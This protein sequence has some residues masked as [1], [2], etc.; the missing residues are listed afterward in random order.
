MYSGKRRDMLPYF[1]LVE[2][3]C[4]SYKNPSDYY[5]DLVTLDDLSAEA[6]LE[7]SQ[8]I[9]QLAEIFRQKQESMSDPGPPSALPMTVRNS[10]CFVQG[11]VLF[12]KAIIY[13]QSTTFFNW[14]SMIILAASI[15]LMLGA[16]FWDIPT[17]DPQLLLN[18]R[19][20]FHY[21]VM[22]LMIWPILLHLTLSEVNRNRRTVERDIRDGLYGR[23]TYIVTKSLLNLF[24]S[25]FVWLIYV[26]PSYSMSGLYM[27][28]L[29]NYDGFY[30][31]VG[32]MLLYLSCL[33]VFLLA[34]IYLVPLKNTAMMISST[35][36]SAFFMSTG[37]VLHLKDLPS[38]LKWLQLSPTSWLLPY[39]LNR[40][41]ADEAIHSLQATV[42]T[43]CRNKQIQ[44]QD[45]IVQ[46]PCPPANGTN[47]LRNFGFLKTDHLVPDYNSPVAL[48]VFFV[49]F[50]VIA[51]VAFVVNCCGRKE[52]SKRMGRNDANKP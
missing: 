20:G 39:F 37:Y 9:E 15:S 2:Y 46:L 12:T 16:I 43:L 32:L 34:F 27:Q 52:S 38:Y 17:S 45:I 31:Y 33:Q 11:I 36:L 5:L 49:I 51:C 26:V 50:F 7:S 44:H 25:L 24:P 42:A 1:A 29:N 10:N 19:Q 48:I 23:T 3:P 6:M 40:E 22:C 14:L 4:P 30:K 41:L 18:D 13:T 8:R 21:T 35:I 47:N 28:S